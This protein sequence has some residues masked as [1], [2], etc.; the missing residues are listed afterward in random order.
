MK[1]KVFAGARIFLGLIYF[2]FGLNGFLQFIPQ[3]PMPES[4]VP[5]MTGL[6]STGYFFPVL[7]A[8]EVIGGLLL[9]TGFAAPLGL[10]LLAPI[11][12]QI[13]LFHWVMTPGIE[14]SL[15]PIVMIA[16]HVTAAVAYWNLYRPLF[17]RKP[18][19]G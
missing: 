15:M 5:F 2:V 6:M 14:N 18:I 11:T 10:I 13:F 3:P 16:L 7:K 12:V 1:Q 4:V 19:L 9:L 17:D 8:T